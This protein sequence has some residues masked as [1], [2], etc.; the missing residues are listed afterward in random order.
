[1]RSFTA[2]GRNCRSG[3]SRF[4]EDSN[5]VNDVSYVSLTFQALWKYRQRSKNICAA[6]KPVG[7]ARTLELRKLTSRYYLS[8]TTTESRTACRMPTES[9]RPCG[10]NAAA[11]LGRFPLVR[12]RSKRRDRLGVCVYPKKSGDFRIGTLE[13]KTTSCSARILNI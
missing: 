12:P 6:N 1:M 7:C 8:K 3:L 9:C 10:S 2:E 13:E 5:I 11:C 4:S